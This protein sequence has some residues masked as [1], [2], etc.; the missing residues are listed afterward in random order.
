[1][2]V[3]IER[4]QEAIFEERYGQLQ[5]AMLPFIV[6]DIVTSYTSSGGVA[7][8]AVNNDIIP[9]IGEP[10]DSVWYPNVRC[11]NRRVQVINKNEQGFIARVECEF[12][13]EYPEHGGAF[14]YPIHGSGH[15][16]Q[17]EVDKKR[18]GT[19]LVFKLPDGSGGLVDKKFTLNVLVPAG[20][21]VIQTTEFGNDPELIKKLYVNKVNEHEWRGHPAKEW[22]CS[23]AEYEPIQTLDD[24]CRWAFR[25][26]FVHQEGGHKYVAL[27]KNPEDGTTPLNNDPPGAV[28]RV[29]VDDWHETAHFGIAFPYILD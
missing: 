16:I 27:W 20:E 13:R 7:G 24:N 11:F 10:L 12:G 29:E 17:R 4:F 6:K 19:P 15:L 1:M 8:E 2:S 28:Y 5:Y 22:L 26:H 23:S 9:E 25:W 18:D 3:A 14:L 21:C